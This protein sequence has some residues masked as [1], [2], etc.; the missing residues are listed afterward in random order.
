MEERDRRQKS[1][2][3]RLTFLKEADEVGIEEACEKYG[4]P[5]STYYY[6]KKKLEGGGE[7]ALSGTSGGENRLRSSSDTSSPSS[8]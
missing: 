4:I 5:R 6:W 7:E 3:E 8:Q 2:E 1:K